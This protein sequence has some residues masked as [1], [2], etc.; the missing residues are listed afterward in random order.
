MQNNKDNVSPKKK[1]KKRKIPL[2]LKCIFI[3]FLLLGIAF[4]LFYFYIKQ[5]TSPYRIATKYAETFMSKDVTALF[6]TMG[7]ERDTFITPESLRNYLREHLNYDKVSAY[8]M[9]EFTNT[10]DENTKQYGITWQ[11]NERNRQ[12]TQTLTLKKSPHKLYFL[13]DN[14]KIDTSEYQA[15]NCSIGVPANAIV[16]IDGIEVPTD[17]A[18]SG[19]ANLSVCKLGSLFPGSHTISV[20]M[21]GFTD[22]F[23]ATNLKSGDY[24]SQNIYTV[25][26]SML[27]IT[28]ETE[29]TLKEDAEKLIHSI[30][31]CALAG[32]SFEKLENACTFEDT[33]KEHLKQAYNT[34]VT[35]HIK[36]AT[37]LTDV[38]FTSY[39]SSTA[40]TYAED[41]CYAVKVSANID[42][43]ANSVVV[44]GDTTE[45][46]S[47]RQNKS[48]PGSS[49]F[50]ITFHYKEGTWSIFDTTAL[51]ACIYYIKY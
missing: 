34:L 47:S 26:P 3:I 50:T 32:K 38:N 44:K 40:T 5:Q 11:T 14:W 10:G 24:S 15:K 12:Y 21:A 8:N 31:E 43:T 33:S 2:A 30:Y 13:F 42:Y 46:D 7:M 22:Y 25:T 28:A 29:K 27:K 48:G 18:S 16:S 49:F 20:R 23:S 9:V 4:T 1:K 45:G 17:K 36:S 41:G 37:H 19:T 6:D 51:D 35:N 39:S